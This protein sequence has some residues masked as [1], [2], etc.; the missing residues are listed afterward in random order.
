[1]EDLDYRILISK[2]PESGM[3]SATTPE[4]AECKAEGA[5]REDALDALQE[6]IRQKVAAYEEEGKE[7]P[8]PLESRQFS[9]EL[10]IQISE[11]LHREVE[12][13]AMY[14]GV[15]RDQ[16]IGE[17]LADGLA[18]RWLAER[19]GRVGGGSKREDKGDRRRRGRKDRISKS[20]YMN[21]ME[22]RA[23]F[24]DYVRGLDSGGGGRRGGGGRGSGG[25]RRGG[26]GRRDRG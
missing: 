24:I 8:E 6:K 15:D 20:R 7:V 19:H 18:R 23:S 22:D 1:M 11:A 14:E 10:R 21:I 26:G 3:Y 4:W 17:I 13:V 12:W 16:L 2:N 9:G 25:G 5:S